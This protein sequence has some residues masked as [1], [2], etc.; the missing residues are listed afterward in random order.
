M[1]QPHGVRSRRIALAKLSLFFLIL[2]GLIVLVFY[3]RD[4]SVSGML[5]TKILVEVIRGAG[6][7][8][9]PVTAIGLIAVASAVSVPLAIIFVVAG[10]AFG[11]W[12]G[13]A[14]A[15]GGATLGAL[16]SFALGSYLG[17]DALV[18]FAGVGIARVSAMLER[19]GVLSVIVIRL[20]PIAPFAVANMLIGTSHIR[21]WQFVIGSVVGMLPGGVFLVSFADWIVGLLATPDGLWVLFRLILVLLLFV[22]VLWISWWF[23][24]RRR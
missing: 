24:F 9:A 14:Y 23:V 16:F 21:L 4:E 6:I 8:T 7:S 11:P 12:L 15:M 19:Y 2:G 17:H 3:W 1:F 5:S 22:T 20:T 13:L 10:L 18:R